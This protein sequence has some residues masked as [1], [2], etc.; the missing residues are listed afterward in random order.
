MKVLNIKR[1]HINKGHV[2]N[3]FNISK[4]LLCKYLKHSILIQNQ[5][6]VFLL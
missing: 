1:V 5:N 2:W 4:D 6:T 3:N